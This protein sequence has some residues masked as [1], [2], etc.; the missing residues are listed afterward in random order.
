[1]QLLYIRVTNYLRMII[2][3]QRGLATVE[4]AIVMV[5]AAGLAGLLIVILK[6]D[7]VRELLEDIIKGAL[8]QGDANATNG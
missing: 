7:F 8:G 1:M 3:D 4:Y 2:K 5:A 6:S